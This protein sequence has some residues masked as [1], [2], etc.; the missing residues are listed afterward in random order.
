LADFFDLQL[1][2]FSARAVAIDPG[3]AGVNHILNAG[4]GEGGFCHIGGQNDA[5]TAVA[6]EDFLLVF[7]AQ[8][9]E[10]GQHFDVLEF[11]RAALVFTQMLGG[12]AYLALAR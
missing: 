10:Q 9:G 11:G 4:H 8:T 12:I 1:L 7:Y 6:F 3:Q 5:A 2:D